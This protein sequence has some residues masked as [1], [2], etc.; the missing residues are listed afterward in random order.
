MERVYQLL[1]SAGYPVEAVDWLRRHRTAT[2]AVM[3]VA[4]WA[5]FVGLGWLIWIVL[6]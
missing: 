4:A 2:I 3:A 1:L 6:T 5:L